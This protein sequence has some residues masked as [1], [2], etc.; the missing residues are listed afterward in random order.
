MDWKEYLNDFDNITKNS[1]CLVGAFMRM[2]YSFYCLFELVICAFGGG[3]FQSHLS[4]VGREGFCFYAFILGIFLGFF[5]FCFA[6]V[7]C[8]AV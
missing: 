7:C 4:H 6:L 1:T 2:G 3:R 8:L 5:F